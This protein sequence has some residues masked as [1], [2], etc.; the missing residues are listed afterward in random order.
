M[1]SIDNK[2]CKITAINKNTCKKFKTLGVGVTCTISDLM[3]VIGS[4]NKLVI[5]NNKVT[6]EK[7]QH[8]ISLIEYSNY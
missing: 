4:P 1:R 3:Y 8:V 2:L 6:F 5:D 7:D